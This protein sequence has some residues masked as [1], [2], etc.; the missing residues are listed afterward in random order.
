M[1]RTV[2]VLVVAGLCVLL[3]GCTIT[4]LPNTPTPPPLPTA[5]PTQA[6]RPTSAPPVTE[7]PARTPPPAALR[8]WAAVREPQE[9]ALRRMLEETA[10]AAQIEVSVTTRS[11]DALY[12]DLTADRLAGEPMPDLVWAS[13]E[14]LALLQRDGLLQPAQD[15]VAAADL[16]PA[17]VIGATIG[18]Q[19]WGTPV[20]ASGAL[21]L[22]YNKQLTSD[23]PATTDELIV[24]SR[25]LNRDGQTGLV[26]GWAEP[27]WFVALLTGYGGALVGAD[28]AP[29]LDTPEMLSALNLLKELR[30]AGPDSPS[31]YADNARLFRR[32]NAAYALDGDWA[33]D[34][35][36]QYTDTLELGIARMPVVPATGR[37]A[38][39]PLNGL[40]LM[41]SS[42]L[43]GTR[44]EQARALALALLQ[45]AAQSRVARDLGVLPALRSA[46]ADPA[47]QQQPGLAAAAAQTDGA[48]GLP[49]DK[50]LR[51]AWDALALW[52][53][54][55]LLD[56]QTPEQAT[57]RMQQDAQTCISKP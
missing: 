28:G 31:T 6:P 55:V 33:L 35:Y 50:R 19:R 1:H 16:L 25:A 3:A 14:E 18:G 43:A 24:R 2:V 57:A 17:T 52:L 53:P 38:A 48:L 41:Y 36:R 47:L 46:L 45:P 49:A 34:S 4:P 9:A 42:E 10:A 44:L 37:V 56:E 8:I 30:V 26:A 20:A 23:V 54:A 22:L 13:Q 29:T 27:R 39:P 15:G 5:R 7:E 51:C 11:P 21:L 32:G 40:Y 12:A